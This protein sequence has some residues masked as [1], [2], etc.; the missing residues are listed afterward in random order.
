MESKFLEFKSLLAKKYNW[1]VGNINKVEFLDRKNKYFTFVLHVN[2][3]NNPYLKQVILALANCESEKKNNRL[4]DEMLIYSY[5]YKWSPQSFKHVGGVY[6]SLTRKLFIMKTVNLEEAALEKMFDFL[7][8][9]GN[10]EE[11]NVTMRALRKN[12]RVISVFG[13]IHIYPNSIILEHE[14]SSS[15]ITMIARYSAIGWCWDTSMWSYQART[16]V[17]RRTNR[18]QVTNIKFGYNDVLPSYFDINYIFVEYIDKINQG[19]KKAWSE[20]SKQDYDESI[21]NSVHSYTVFILTL[22]LN[23]YLGLE[24]KPLFALL[25]VNRFNSGSETSLEDYMQEHLTTFLPQS[26]YVAGGIFDD[27]TTDLIIIRTVRYNVDV[28]ANLIKLLGTRVKPEINIK[29]QDINSNLKILRGEF[30]LNLK[31]ESINNLSLD[32]IF[33]F[34]LDFSSIGLKEEDLWVAVQARARAYFRLKKLKRQAKSNK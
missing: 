5:I 15:F 14:H 13:L 19:Y 7:V 27:S 3:T 30:R 2:L 25:N 22:N 29:I 34:L 1:Y 6:N 28:I 26:F 16:A 24:L 9:V 21:T 33:K 23:K 11:F 17:L 4:N 20:F 31:S 8:L 18:S 12:G 32:D 10:V